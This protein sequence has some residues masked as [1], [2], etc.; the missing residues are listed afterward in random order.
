MKI[1]LKRRRILAVVV[2]VL[3]LPAYWVG[4]VS[5]LTVREDRACGKAVS[6]ARESDNTENKDLQ[7]VL[8]NYSA[9]SGVGLQATVVFPNGTVWSGTSGYASR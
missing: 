9:E 3:M 2:L 8:D 4:Y 1:D 5:Y 7:N 6:L